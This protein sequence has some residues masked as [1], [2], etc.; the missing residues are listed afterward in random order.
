MAILLIRKPLD[1]GKNVE[2]GLLVKK[3]YLPLQLTII[4]VD[5]NSTSTNYSKTNPR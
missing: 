2:K 3:K 5:I 1:R 4:F